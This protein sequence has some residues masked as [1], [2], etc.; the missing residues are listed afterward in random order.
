MAGGTGVRKFG[1]SYPTASCATGGEVRVSRISV[2]LH[3]TP[4]FFTDGYLYQE[5]T[6]K[7]FGRAR[8]EGP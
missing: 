1:C 3:L 2:D 5:V 6:T 4:G 7:K 8:P